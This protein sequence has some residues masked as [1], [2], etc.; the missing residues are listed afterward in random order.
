MGMMIFYTAAG[1]RALHYF[2]T[3]WLE[4]RTHVVL[5]PGRRRQPIA[6]LGVGLP[7]RRLQHLAGHIAHVLRGRRLP[8]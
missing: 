6:V 4:R 1:V 8:E 2:L 7:P 5:E 3:Q